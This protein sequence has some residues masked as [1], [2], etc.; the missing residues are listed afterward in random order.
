[1][2]ASSFALNARTETDPQIF[3]TQFGLSILS[4]GPIADYSLPVNR[5]PDQ[6]EKAVAFFKNQYGV[7]V[8]NKGANLPSTMT[9]IE[10]VGNLYKVNYAKVRGREILA[11]SQDLGVFDDTISVIITG[12]S[13][14][15][16]N[17]G[18][19]NG[20]WVSPGAA[21]I[22][23]FYT[24]YWINNGTQAFPR[25]IFSAPM[26]MF[27]GADG[28]LLV[29]CELSNNVW[30]KGMARGV[31]T[32]TYDAATQKTWV[33][34]VS[35]HTYQSSLTDLSPKCSVIMNN[36]DIFDEDYVVR[37]NNVLL[38]LIRD[39]NV[40]PPVA[41][42]AMAILHTAIE[43]AVDDCKRLKNSNILKCSDAT[44]NIAIS[45]AA[46]RVLLNLFPAAVDCLNSALKRALD[47]F[48]SATSAQ[49]ARG[50]RNGIIAAD[51]ILNE[52]SNDGSSDFVDYVF[53]NDAF[54]YQSDSPS[55]SRFPGLPNWAQ[56]QPFAIEDATQY[57]QGPAPGFGTPDFEAAY[58]EVRDYGKNVSTVRTF[59]QRRIAWFW[60]D[61]GGTATP[62]GHWNVILQCIIR[63]QGITD[64]YKIATLFKLLGVAVADAGIVA[65][66]H[67]Y[68]YNTLRPVTAI[69]YR[70]FNSDWFPLLGTPNHPEYVSGHST[71]SGAASKVLAL[72]FGTDN[73]TFD[74]VS[75]GYV[76]HVRTFNSFS[77]AAKEAGKSRIYGGIHFDYSNVAGYNAG[78]A[79]ANAVFESLCSNSSCL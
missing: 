74:T 67:K 36:K 73:I 44:K 3:D 68:H 52:R 16:G 65:W 4:D 60:A 34:V 12:N 70:E 56:V 8:S 17:W 58:V 55:F 15:Y 51:R 31:M 50:K 57:R 59:D 71:F 20:T 38:A 35:S 69:R 11:G 10:G 45:Y 47:N 53:S 76:Q 42:R 33:S 61:N 40:D 5:Y 43:D 78:T 77:S 25:S 2:I 28:S 7:D 27:F 23:G 66:D 41:T 19:K 37:W 9:Y 26:P 64:T 49:V 30:G 18:G 22:Y 6:H 21:L 79:V 75:D 39:G 46:H 54:A 29:D 72:A 48:A 24:F 13:V 32:Y 62:P 1:M 14:L 63:Q